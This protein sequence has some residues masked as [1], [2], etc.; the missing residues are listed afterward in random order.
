MYTVKELI[1]ALSQ[2]PPDYRIVIHIGE[3]IGVPDTIGF[4]PAARTVDIFAKP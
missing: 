2:L 1:E 3:S 4:H